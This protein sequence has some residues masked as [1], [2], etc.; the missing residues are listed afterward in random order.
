MLHHILL[1]LISD[2]ILLYNSTIYFLPFHSHAHLALWTHT[3]VFI[4]HSS[5]NNSCF[6]NSTGGQTTSS[7]IL[8]MQCTCTCLFIAVSR[9]WG[10]E[11]RTHIFPL[12]RK[13]R[14]DRVQSHI[15]Q[16]ASSYMTKYWRNFSYFRKHFLIHDFAT[17]PFFIS[18]YRRK[19]FYSFLTV[20]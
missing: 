20:Y 17:A 14:K 2:N 10:F 9:D 15:W 3:N 12:I 16:T 18:L 1:R 4:S 7:S 8:S 13:F 11:P 6:L 5:F 19:I